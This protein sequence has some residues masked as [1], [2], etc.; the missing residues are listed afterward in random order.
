[1]PQPPPLDYAPP[2]P[3]GKRRRL[4]VQIGVIVSACVVLVGS[5]CGIAL[6][7]TRYQINQIH[8]SSSMRQIGQ[9]IMLYTTDNGGSYPPDLQTVLLTQ[10]IAAYAF[11]CPSSSDSVTNGASMV[12]A[13]ADMAK[14]GHCS[15]I[16]LGSGLT[17]PLD[18]SCIVMIED[19]ANHDLNGT[20]VLYADGH[21]D[22]ELLETVMTHLNDLN[23]G[24]N[25]PTSPVTMT[26][27]QARKDYEKNWKQRM[28]TLKTGVWKIPTTQ[29]LK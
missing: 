14:P 3:R 21:V 17:S 16:Y 8:C 26:A 7:R 10:T 4:A 29:P 22:W 24:T 18:P 9:A 1:M 23:K 11:V 15:C 5:L 25:P 13:A 28:P 12:Q 19:P 2:D 20:N 27:S 6:S